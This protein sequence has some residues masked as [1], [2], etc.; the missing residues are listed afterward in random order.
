MSD[1]QGNIITK[2]PATPTGPLS[3]GSA[4]GMWRLD[5]VA[6]WIKQGVWPD[7]N[8]VPDQYFPYV[9]LLLSSTSLGNANN[10]LFVDSSGA[11]N[12]ISRNGNTTQGS[13]TPYGA[14]WSNYFNGSSALTFSQINMAGDFTIE[15]WVYYT[16]TGDGT[17]LGALP[18]NHQSLRRV[19]GK[20]YFYRQG[21]D[22]TGTIDLP[23]NQWV[24]LAATRSS[25]EVRIFTNGVL[26]G[27]R[28]ITGT[29]SLFCLGG[30]N[31]TTDR[32]TGYVSN[33]RVVDGTALYT[34]TFTPPT[35]PLMAVSG[36][37]LLTSQSNRFRDAGPN[38]LTLTI[39]GSPSVTEFSPFAPAYPGITYNQSDIT[40]WSGYFDG[41][42]DYLTLPS[43]AAF[44]FGTGDFTVECWVYS[45]NAAS[46][47]YVIVDARNS[48]QT[49]TW[50]LFRNS[51]NQIEWYNG[52]SSYLT[53]TNIPANQWN[54]VAYSRSGTTG[55]V[56]LN[57]AVV[58]TFTDATNY[59]VSPTTSYIGCRYSVGE[60][61]NGYLSNT[62]VVKGTALYTGSYTVPTAPLTAVSG[63]SLLTCQNAAFTD[64]STNNFAITINGNTTVTGNSP[65]NPEGYWSLAG[66]TGQG[67]TIP[68]TTAT[69]LGS[70]NFTVECWVNTLSYNATIVTKRR[71][72]TLLTGSWMLAVNPSGFFTFQG[73]GWASSYQATT[74]AIPVGAWTHLAVSRSGTNLSMFVNG[75]RVYNVTDSY[76]YTCSTYTIIKLGGNSGG[77]YPS[78]GALSFGINGSISNLRIVQGT[79]VYDPA[80]T[81]VT[82]PTSPLTA[83]S[84]TSLLTCQ[85]GTMKDNSTNNNTSIL[86]Y[87]GGSIQSFD[88][89][90]T[91]TTASNGGS[92]AL[93]GTGDYLNL[94]APPLLALGASSFTIEGW[95]YPRANTD[96][97]LVDFRPASVNG[98][99]PCIYLNSSGYLTYYVSSADRISG[100]TIVP[101]N[102]WSHFAVCRSG[103]STTL[104]LNGVQ[105][106]AT[107]SDSNSYLVGAG[108]PFIGANGFGSGSNAVNGYMADVRFTNGTAV[109]TSAFTP[110][111]APLTPTANTSLLVNGMNA[112][113]Y[114]AAT[115]N[116]METVGNAQVSTAVSKFGGSSMAFDGT[117]D[118]LTSNASS[119]LYAFGT[120]DFTI[121]MWVNLSS[122]ASLQILYDSRPASTD[123]LY[124]L[125]Y[126][127][128]GGGSIIWQISATARITGTA[129]LA[130]GTWYHV[131]VSR[132]SGST[133]MFLNGT[134]VGSTY[135]DT[136]AYLNSGT[137]RPFIGGSS[138]SAGTLTVN[139]Y[140]DD[141]RVTKGVAR[142]T[143]TFTPPTQA[144]PPY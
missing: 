110:P 31:T 76:N 72:D 84:G 100:S 39:N 15:S 27:S 54:H 78:G 109:Y 107:Y 128:S 73:V 61:L 89:F 29:F 13:A 81:T 85:N 70:G 120:G 91:S 75:V 139:G 114:D 6:Y 68:Q 4:P 129:T 42:G 87:G 46:T 92:I 69:D 83:I 133:K 48:G 132:A 62:R 99:Y 8:I 24:H 64:N 77:N 90:Y 40:N 143:T 98:V 36:T 20:H 111:T 79:A 37:A 10:N 140:I 106:G 97:L 34:A 74:N 117:G 118:Y 51:S 88:P 141:L 86:L 30:I 17:V 134:Q 71:T 63:T 25:G 22:I 144:F 112:G 2:S 121:E 126:V 12:P 1:Y 32:L 119:D 47:S 52:S 18:P 28:T 95:V 7:T 3:T 135:A 82:V 80:S 33:V 101:L 5:E 21:V 26:D 123:G 9:S 16:G 115:I 108:R 142:Y 125:I 96:I 59:S 131:A 60:F 122:F 14:S 116:D 45:S 19:S 23:V 11:F 50:V 66:T 35:A 113:V 104:Y 55:R 53:S 127:S 38:N 65:F 67:A 124:P 41:S 136:N 102:A 43:G 94:S 103:T 105:Q 138:Y 58:G 130:T 56:L 57:G 44:Q 49:G 93:D 137:T